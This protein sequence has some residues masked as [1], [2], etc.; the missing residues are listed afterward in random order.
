VKDVASKAADNAARLAALFH[1]FA[2]QGPAIGPESF[3]GASRIVAWH[4]SESRRFFGEMALPAELADAVRLDAWLVDYCRRNRTHM[5]S[6]RE[7]QQYGPVRDKGRQDTALN[8]L[9]E[10]ARV[11]QGNEARRKFVRVNP[12]LLEGKP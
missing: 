2:G 3:E 11:R 6:T 12:A 4:L 1:L 5:V 9:E 8:V 10:F 7:A